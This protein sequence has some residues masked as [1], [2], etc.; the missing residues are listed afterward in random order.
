MN[1]SDKDCKSVDVTGTNELIFAADSLNLKRFSAAL[2]GC[3][4]KDV[5]ELR[6]KGSTICW[7]RNK[8]LEGYILPSN[9]IIFLSI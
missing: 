3:N 6:F 9:Q 8:R 2:D 4:E 5:Y 1:G 7:R